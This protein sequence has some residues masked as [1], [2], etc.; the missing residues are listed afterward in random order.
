MA[1]WH[2]RLAKEL[3]NT[4]IS[5]IYPKYALHKDLFEASDIDKW[6]I[7]EFRGALAPW[8]AS[9]R[10]E[11]IDIEKLPRVRLDAPGIISFD[12]LSNEFCDMLVNEASHYRS[13]GMPQQAPNSMNNYGLVLNEVGLRPTFDKVLQGFL[14]GIGARLFGG[15]A[16]R[17]T[18]LHGQPLCTDMW[19]GG[20]LDYHH[21]FI[22]RYRP[23]EDRHLDMHVDDCDVTF[24]FGLTE[25]S[26][27]GGSDLAFCGMRGSESHRRHSCTYKHD[28]GRCV[29]HAGKLRHGAMDIKSGERHN[30]I[31]WT[32]SKGYRQ[33]VDY[34]LKSL[35]PVKDE[36]ADPD[37]MC[38]SETHDHDFDMWLRRLA[39]ETPA[40]PL[41]ADF[42]EKGKPVLPVGSRGGTTATEEKH[43]AKR[44]HE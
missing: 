26:D 37:R 25:S 43:Q 22:V 31:V 28:K 6:F 7:P 36:V 5:Q 9:R 2:V 34:Q 39:G 38:L 32:K 29:V 33:T 40:E 11:D 1:A 20:T 21:T 12:C 15:D 10:A 41:S 44:P 30:L 19:G 14:L 8:Q 27:F 24:N 4:G 16:N 23:D 17:A 18:E 13:L 42:D 3:R 35:G